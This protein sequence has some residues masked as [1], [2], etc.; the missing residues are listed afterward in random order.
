MDRF[1]ELEVFLAVADAGSFAKAAT[2]LRLS[3]P[4]ITRAVAA[5]E[6]RLGARVFHRTTRS[7]TITDVGQRFLVG[8]RR[9]VSDFDSAQLDAVGA[10][11]V[12]QGQLTLTTSVTFGRKVLA[13]IV[14]DFL[15]GQSRLAITLLLV[16]RVV[17]L[18]EEGIDAAVRIGPLPDST[19]I[20]RRVG[21]VSRVWVASPRYLAQRG[22]PVVPA[23]LR[24]HAVIAHTGLLPS[25]E[26]RFAH[27][28]GVGTVDLRPILEANDATVAIDA[29]RHGH[30]IAAA[31][32]YMVGD[33]LQGGELVSVLDEFQLAAEP[34]HIVYPSAR[35]I[36]PK[37]RAFVDYAAPQLQIAL[38]SPLARPTLSAQRGPNS[39]VRSKV[40]RESVPKD[41]SQRRRTGRS[42]T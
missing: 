10:T 7:L 3:P 2:R 30:G 21:S 9:L 41:R 13:P 5:L 15:A 12:P 1:H 8:A 32:S 33:A 11:A 28:S 29:A 40:Q 23:D 20:A 27:G 35:L 17:N 38:A 26:W 24:A 42:R 25:R 4:A 6:Q 39:K 19:L 14:L 18:V 31:L 22:S 16:D 37:V 36:A 34:V